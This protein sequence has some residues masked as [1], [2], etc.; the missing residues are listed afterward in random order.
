MQRGKLNQLQ[1]L[2]AGIPR[3]ESMRAHERLAR[4]ESY[5]PKSR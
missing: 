2:I 1:P 4:I 5:E 3:A